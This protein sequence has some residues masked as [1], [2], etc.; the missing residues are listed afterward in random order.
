MQHKPLTLA[1]SHILPCTAHRASDKDSSSQ[2]MKVSFWL[3]AVEHFQQ[4][5]GKHNTELI[6]SITALLSGE[7]DILIH[8]LQPVKT[9]K[10]ALTSA[11]SNAYSKTCCYVEKGQ[12]VIH[13]F[14]WDF[15]NLCKLKEKWKCIYVLKC[16]TCLWTPKKDV[17]GNDLKDMELTI[18]VHRQQQGEWR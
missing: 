6:T 5:T 17:T 2:Q 12:N 11:R 14:C 4:C 3:V 10:A 13:K 16:V 18:V 9:G 8:S 7:D 1:L 15:H